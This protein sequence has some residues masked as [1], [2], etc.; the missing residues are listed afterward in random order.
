M[1]PLETVSWPPAALR[2]EQEQLHSHGVRLVTRTKVECLPRTFGSWAGVL[3]ENEIEGAINDAAFEQLKNHLGM[4]QYLKT[5]SPIQAVIQRCR[6]AQQQIPGELEIPDAELKHWERA[7]RA[8]ASESC[9]PSS[10]CDS[11][12]H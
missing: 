9:S 6:R 7:D 4:G 1:K 3:M 8:R 11:V 5:R 10:V 2:R 12:G